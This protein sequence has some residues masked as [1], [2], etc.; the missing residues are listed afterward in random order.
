M[1]M[2]LTFVTEKVALQITK[3]MDY[4][5]INTVIIPIYFTIRCHC[6]AKDEMVQESAVYTFIQLVVSQNQ[7]TKK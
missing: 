7:I 1:A 3:W 4:H 2:D 6:H 5:Q